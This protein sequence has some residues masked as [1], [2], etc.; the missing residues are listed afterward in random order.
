MGLKKDQETQ[1]DGG[2]VTTPLQAQV[3]SFPVRHPRTT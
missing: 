1:D 2:L 3:L